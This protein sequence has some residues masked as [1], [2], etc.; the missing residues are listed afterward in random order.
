MN[1]WRVKL[2]VDIPRYKIQLHKFTYLR[3]Y[4]KLEEIQGWVNIDKAPNMY[5]TAHLKKMEKKI[6][7]VEQ[8]HLA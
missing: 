8:K 6:H 1:W 2:L 5:L 3:L 4:L 7:L